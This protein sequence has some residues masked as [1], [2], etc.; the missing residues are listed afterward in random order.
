MRYS[1][2]TE[3]DHVY[4]IVGNVCD[5]A[6]FHE[7]QENLKESE[8]SWPLFVL[9]LNIIS[10]LNT[11]LKLYPTPLNLLTCTCTVFFMTDL[12]LFIKVVCLIH[13]FLSLSFCLFV[14]SC[15]AHHSIRG[16]SLTH[17]KTEEH[18]LLT[19]ILCLMKSLRRNQDEKCCQLWSP[20]SFWQKL[21]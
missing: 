4:L 12:D 9:C 13:S 1:A 20:L 10:V 18:S 19:V 21:V 16:P 5:R 2:G 14:Y 7:F 15:R 11:K 6:I 17:L 8:A 3:P